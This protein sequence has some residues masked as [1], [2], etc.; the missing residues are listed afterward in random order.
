MSINGND[1]IIKENNEKETDNF[2]NI[3]LLEKME[4]KSLSDEEKQEYVRY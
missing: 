1:E 3:R 2:S 4:Y